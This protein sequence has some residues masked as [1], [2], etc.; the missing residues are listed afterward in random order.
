MPAAVEEAQ[1]CDPRDLFEREFRIIESVNVLP[2]ITLA[3]PRLPQEFGGFSLDH[4][5]CQHTPELRPQ[6]IHQRFA[7]AHS[8]C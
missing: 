6:R 2:E 1:K 5:F 4:T 3:H 7:P 8:D